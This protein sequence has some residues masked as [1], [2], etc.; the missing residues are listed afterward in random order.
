MSYLFNKEVVREAKKYYG[1]FALVTNCEKD[2]FKCL[3]A[4]RKRETIES[5]F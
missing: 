4:Y 1:Y 3:Q 2:H 5:F